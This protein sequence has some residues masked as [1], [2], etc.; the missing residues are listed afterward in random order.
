MNYGGLLIAK[1][2]FAAS[3]FTSALN[4]SLLCAK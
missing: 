3:G 1:R 4:A 2:R